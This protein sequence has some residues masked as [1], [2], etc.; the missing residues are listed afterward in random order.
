MGNIFNN[1]FLDFLQELNKA[2]VDYVLVGGYAVILHGY[3][4]VTGDMDILVRPTKENYKKLKAAFD[5]FGMPV[6]DMTEV[7]FLNQAENDVFTFGRQPV[8]ID[9]MTA[10]KGADFDVISKESVLFTEGDVAVRT[11]SLL[12]LQQLKKASGRPKDQDDIDHL[13]IG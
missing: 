1:D 3:S 5:A 10:I 9:I 6:F 8:S 13:A 4:R 11:V 2:G 12:W 7:K